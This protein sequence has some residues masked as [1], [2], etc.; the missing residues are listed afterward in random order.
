ML[1]GVRGAITVEEDTVA[2]ILE[3]TTFMLQTLMTANQIQEEDVAS[4]LFTTTPDLTACY[5]AKAAR[6]LGWKQVA[7]MGFQEMHVPGGLP[8]CV[9][10]LIH[11]NTPRPQQE[12]THAFL[13]GAAVLRPDLQ[14]AGAQAEEQGS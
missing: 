14:P 1:R 4:V 3:A 2:A 7:L 12:V 11:W 5:P 9:R 8:L 13:R 10:V 6:D